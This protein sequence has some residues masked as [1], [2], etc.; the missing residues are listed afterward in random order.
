MFETLLLIL[1][2]TAVG[3]V[4]GAAWMLHTIREYVDSAIDQLLVDDPENQPTADTGPIFARMEKHGDVLYL[5]E[6]DTDVFLA[7]GHDWKEVSRALKQRFKHKHVIVDEKEL[8]DKIDPDG[9]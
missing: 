8:L 4:L 1:V 3:F 6:K 7:Q 2:S 5:F 9:Q